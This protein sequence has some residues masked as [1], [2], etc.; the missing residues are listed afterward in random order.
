MTKNNQKDYVEFIVEDCGLFSEIQGFVKTFR[1][2]PRSVHYFGYRGNK[3][4]ARF[5]LL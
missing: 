2:R 5:P 3:L 1:F 4:L